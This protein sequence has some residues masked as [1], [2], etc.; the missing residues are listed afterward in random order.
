M[1]NK[2]RRVKW[3]FFVIVSCQNRSLLFRIISVTLGLSQ[4]T[5]A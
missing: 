4:A 1:L 3:L 2:K 5:Q